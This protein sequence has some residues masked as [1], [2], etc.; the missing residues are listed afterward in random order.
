[1]FSGLIVITSALS[2]VGESPRFAKNA[3]LQ[4]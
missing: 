1:M 3:T 4:G 2:D